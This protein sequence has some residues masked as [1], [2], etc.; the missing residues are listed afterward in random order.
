MTRVPNTHCNNN[1][2]FDATNTYI[3]PNG[4]R[5]CRI[6]RRAARKGSAA[7]ILRAPTTLL[8]MSPTDLAWLAGWL[9]GEGTFGFQQVNGVVY[10]KLAA[11][12]TDHDTLE[13]AQAITG[14]GRIMNITKQKPHHKQS[15][16]WNV[17]RCNDVL[18][19]MQA[20]EPL[21]MSRRQ[22]RIHEVIEL[23]EGSVFIR[24]VG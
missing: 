4:E 8:E 18:A 16:I 2:P 23:V 3:S 15:W 7:G 11:A 1:H 19:L 13:R 17:Y 9:E 22:A 5:Q 12:S 20:I 24:K 6:C 10:P 21:M 14:V